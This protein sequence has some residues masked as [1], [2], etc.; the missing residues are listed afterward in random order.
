M[1]CS[2][3]LLETLGVRLD[4]LPVVEPLLDDD[5]CIMAFSSATSL[6]GLNCSMWVAWRFSAWPRGSMTIELARRAWPPA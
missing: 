1:T 5:V 2:R 4:V 3:E 6:P